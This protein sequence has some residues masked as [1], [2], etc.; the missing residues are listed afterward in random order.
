[1]PTFGAAQSNLLL[2]VW[3]HIF[4][5]QFVHKGEA[6]DTSRNFPSDMMIFTSK[7]DLQ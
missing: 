3:N 7:L 1:M 5:I 4:V 6:W 2:T